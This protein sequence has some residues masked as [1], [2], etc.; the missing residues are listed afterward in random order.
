MIFL[1]NF[2]NGDKIAVVGANGIGEF[3]CID[4]YRAAASWYRITWTRRNCSIWNLWSKGYRDWKEKI[5]KRTCRSKR[6]TLHGWST[7][8]SYG[9]KLLKQFQFCH[10]RWNDRV[11]ML[12]GG[13]CRRL[14]LMSVLMKRPNFLV[15]SNIAPPNLTWWYIQFMFSHLL[16]LLIA[17]SLTSLFD[18]TW[19]LPW[20][21]QEHI[22][23]CVSWSLLHR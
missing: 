19:R 4:P 9:K 10:Q 2:N 7:T 15:V 1:Y 13:E 14:Q 16:F 12:S 17:H 3:A 20:R 18:S 11:S 23:N 6:W 5:Y 22:G 8:R 21:V